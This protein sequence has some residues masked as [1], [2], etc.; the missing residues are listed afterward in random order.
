M[1]QFESDTGSVLSDP[2]N[3]VSD[4]ETTRQLLMMQP[5]AARNGTYASTMQP[6]RP[7]VSAGSQGTYAPINIEEI[8]R[9]IVQVLNETRSYKC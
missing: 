2:N 4:Q 3:P 6:A 8:V 5:G 9:A 1:E 7:L